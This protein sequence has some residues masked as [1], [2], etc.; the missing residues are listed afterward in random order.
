MKSKYKFELWFEFIRGDVI[1]PEICLMIVLG[2]KHFL[3]AHH[4]KSTEVIA[5]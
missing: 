2:L 4:S 5:A 1:L 3:S